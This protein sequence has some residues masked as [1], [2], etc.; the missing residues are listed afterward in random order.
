MVEIILSEK[1][2]ELFQK[3]E[4]MQVLNFIMVG[5][6]SKA[7]ANQI[8]DNELAEEIL[9]ILF[10][11]V[12]KFIEKNP[13]VL[14]RSLYKGFF[15]RHKFLLR[16][17]F[18]FSEKKGV[19]KRIKYGNSYRLYV[20][21]KLTKEDFLE[22]WYRTKGIEEPEEIIVKSYP[23]CKQMIE[24]YFGEEY[25]KRLFSHVWKKLQ[26]DGWFEHAKNEEDARY[27]E[28]IKNNQYEIL[29]A[30]IGAC[31]KFEINDALQEIIDMYWSDEY[32][33]LFKRYLSKYGFF[34]EEGFLTEYI[35]IIGIKKHNELM[36]K[37]RE[38]ASHFKIKWCGFW[39]P[40]IK[41]YH[42]LWDYIQSLKF[43]WNI[44][45]SM[46]IKKCKKCGK[47]F[48]P[49]YDLRSIIHKIPKYY[50]YI[51]TINDI[52]FCPNHAFGEFNVVTNRRKEYTMKISK[53]K[54]AQLLKELINVTGVIPPSNFK[55]DLSYLKHLNKEKYE[56]AIMILCDMPPYEK[57]FS[58]P[59]G[60]K[61]VFG[62]WFKALA[63]A[64]VDIQKKARGYTCLAE[65]GHVCFSLGEKKI[66]DWL[67]R[68]RI[69]HEK[70]PKYPGDS[71]LRG[72]WK[73]GNYFIEYWGLK[74]KKDY[75]DKIFLKKEIA[76]ENKIKLIEI[77]PKDLNNLD[78]KLHILLKFADNKLSKK[79]NKR[80]Q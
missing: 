64:G 47:E 2:K 15:E 60:Y 32:E 49:E 43:K 16:G 61:D 9:S 7:N 69:P 37:L 33:T 23:R 13:G 79:V 68:H 65:D 1:E 39:W 31:L 14:Q 42:I 45:P 41:H 12:L 80:T 48:Y 8:V 40:T 17:F 51:K 58:T 11:K 76:R 38:N 77:N 75:D 3:A 44:K 50:P 52:N 22:T 4:K 56:Q 35:K 71:N 10:N 28:I 63:A 55:K 34:S 6:P 36:N 59:Y 57:S 5:N 21:K 26:E 72:D 27:M 20:E 66:D 74:G 19:L 67:Y 18:Y 30:D 62:S 73:V 24:E 53:D 29:I 54:M 70:E 25:L 78:E 46:V